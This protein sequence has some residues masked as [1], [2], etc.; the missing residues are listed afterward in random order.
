MCRRTLPTL[1][2]H[3]SAF[4]KIIKEARCAVK[5]E[6]RPK[7]GHFVHTKDVIIEKAGAFLVSC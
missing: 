5:C 6:I 1:G 2:I 7:R 3:I 4:V